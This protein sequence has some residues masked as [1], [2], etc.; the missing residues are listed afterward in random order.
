[1]AEKRSLNILLMVGILVCLFQVWWPE[2]YVTGDGPCH[3]YNAKVLHDIWQGKDVPFYTAFYHVI[4]QP[5]PNWLSHIILG[6]LMY[7]V[8]GV[9]AEKLF[10]S[11]YILLLTG[12]FYLL[13]K[14][15]SGASSYWFIV[16][17]FFVFHHTLAKGFYNFALSTAF[18]FWMVWSW[19]NLLDKKNTANTLLFFCSSGLVFFTQLLPFVFGEFACL[20]LL[21]SYSVS[22]GY[23]GR[24]RP[25]S[26]FVKNSIVLAMLTAPFVFVMF[27]FTDKEGGMKIVLWP[28]LYR[29]IELVQF[30]YSASGSHNEDFFASVA[31]ITM[32]TLV[33]AC[34]VVRLRKGY[35]VNKY[36]GLFISLLFL[37]F[38]C[39][40]FPED[41]MKRVI[42]ISMRAQLFIYILAVCCIAYMLPEKLKNACGFIIFACF[43]G[44][45]FVHVS[46]L[47]K[48]SE[49]VADITAASKFIRPY[50]VILPLNF[51]PEGRDENWKPISNLN[52]FFSHAYDYIGTEKPLIFL[53]NYEALTGYFPL[54]WTYK[55]NPYAHLS[56]FEGI[57]GQPPSADISGYYNSSGVRID[58]IL[59]WCYDSSYLDKGHYRQLSAQIDSSYRLL[60]VS[61]TRRTILYERN[62]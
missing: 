44:M 55:T 56:T 22:H 46:Y 61:P 54:L 14:K 43:F 11:A 9:V 39:I 28:H 10:L 12:G 52:F 18:Y 17:F 48:A 29:L 26:F 32:T 45:S 8:N 23:I 3:L 20:A 50:S 42:L 37:L 19:L 34:I 4:Y 24:Q 1:M 40:F 30:R 53:D 25:L 47:S 35:V 31:G 6:A 36:D 58:Y 16:I 41:F 21:I 5:N 49:A 27:W 57:E 62:N 33:I 59:M 51:S 38:V 15:I 7:L 13:L 60:Y 2:Y